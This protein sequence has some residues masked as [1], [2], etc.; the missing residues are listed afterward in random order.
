MLME[1][2]SYPTALLAEV[3][4]RLLPEKVLE[5]DVF[6][7]DG[8]GNEVNPRQAALR[9][10]KKVA[11][12]EVPGSAFDNALYWALRLLRRVQEYGE[13]PLPALETVSM[14]AGMNGALVDFFNEVDQVEALANYELLDSE[15]ETGTISDWE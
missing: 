14:V 10:V 9:V 5:S 11:V 4:S 15:G 7:F 12:E 8:K 2:E 13:Q 3:L 6:F 1:D